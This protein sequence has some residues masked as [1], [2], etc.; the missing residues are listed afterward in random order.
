MLHEYDA[1][2]DKCPLPLV[3]MRMILKKM[4]HDDVC[5]LRIRDKGSLK[6]I[7]KYLASAGYIFT[8]R[9]VD[10]TS[11]ELSIKKQVS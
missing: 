7:P 1:T 11:V 5:L 9:I 8:Q 3:N 2:Q 4:Q 6:D 10:T